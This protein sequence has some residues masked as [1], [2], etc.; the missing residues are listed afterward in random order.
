MRQQTLRAICLH[1][2]SHNSIARRSSVGLHGW[3][4]GDLR[5]TQVCRPQAHA[6]RAYL[7][8]LYRAEVSLERRLGRDTSSARES[9]DRLL[10]R[11]LEREVRRVVVG[12]TAHLPPSPSPRLPVS[13]S[14]PSL[15]VNRPYSSLSSPTTTPHLTPLAH[16]CLLSDMAWFTCVYTRRCM[17]SGLAWCRHV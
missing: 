2:S 13:A 7:E 14:V 6:R 15:L 1:T 10:R 12:L 11:L 5:H 9:L 4:R 8:R 3:R 17:S 16:L